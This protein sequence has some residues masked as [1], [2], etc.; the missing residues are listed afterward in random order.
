MKNLFLGIW[1][2]LEYRFWV[3]E[4]GF[5]MERQAPWPNR[6]HK[7]R[8]SKDPMNSGEGHGPDQLKILFT[9]W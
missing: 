8:G 9:L 7:L 2:H 3:I 5:V 6:M 1:M 4:R